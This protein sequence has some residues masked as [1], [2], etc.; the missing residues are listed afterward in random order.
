M[1]YKDFKKTLLKNKDFRKEYEKVALQRSIVNQVLL[2]RTERGIT[3]TELAKMIGTKQESI[4]RLESG[5]RLPSLT[6]LKKVTTALK[7]KLVVR[8]NKEEK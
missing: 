7:T 6:L 4:S 2:L 8:L 1:K 3:Q 5:N